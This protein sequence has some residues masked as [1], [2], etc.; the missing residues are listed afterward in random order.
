MQRFSPS[1]HQRE[2]LKQKIR[3]QF[4]LTSTELDQF[5]PADLIFEVSKKTGRLRLIYEGDTLW[6]M[7]RPND[8]FFLFSPLSAKTLIRIVP[9]PRLRVVVQSA[10][11]EFIRKGK[12]VFAKHTVDCD[13]SLPPY[14]EIIVVDEED[15]PLAIGK[16]LLTKDEMLSFN[17]GVAVKVRKGIP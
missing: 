6:G 15:N 9:S 1:E 14:S 2:L 5:V 17:I 16:L 8:G 3:Y 11:A 10:V 7:I 13:P 4:S 12:N